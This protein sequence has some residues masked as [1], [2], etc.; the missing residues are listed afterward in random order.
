MVQTLRNISGTFSEKLPEESFG[1]FLEEILRESPEKFL[2][3]TSRGAST[4]ISKSIA[5]KKSIPSVAG[6]ISGWIIRGASGECSA[7]I[8]WRNGRRNIWMLSAISSEI[9]PTIPVGLIL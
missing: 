2:K 1:N 5:A 7:I 9:D 8:S 6:E 4:K 3:R